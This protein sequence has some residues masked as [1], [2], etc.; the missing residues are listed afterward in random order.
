[1]LDKTGFP[2]PALVLDITESIIMINPDHASEV[3]HGIRDLGVKIALDDFGTGYSSL[4]NLKKFPIDILKIDRSF[5]QSVPEDVENTALTSAII[6]LGE[7]L[8]LLVVAEG[9]ENE[10]QKLFLEAQNCPQS[11]GFLFHIPLEPEEITKLL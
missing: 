3:L 4:S 8:N 10:A 11:Q 7:K 1:M 9:V 2:P 5:L 6:A